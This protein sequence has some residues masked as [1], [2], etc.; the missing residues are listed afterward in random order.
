MSFSPSD[1]AAKTLNSKA[2]A[3]LVCLSIT[4]AGFVVG[5]QQYGSAMF[6]SRS[7]TEDRYA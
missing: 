1:A 3:V 5:G 7:L 6:V 2:V 4:R